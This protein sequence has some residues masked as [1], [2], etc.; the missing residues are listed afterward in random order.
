MKEKKKLRVF[1]CYVVRREHGGVYH[2]LFGVR[3]YPSLIRGRMGGIV[4]CIL[5]GCS[6]FLAIKNLDIISS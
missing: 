6:I 5:F 3:G 1:Y 2:S 4:W